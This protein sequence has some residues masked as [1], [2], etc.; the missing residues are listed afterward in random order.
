LVG[1][2]TNESKEKTNHL[3]TEKKRVGG[4]G[5]VPTSSE[6]HTTLVHELR[7]KGGES[8]QRGYRLMKKKKGKKSPKKKKE[9]SR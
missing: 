3:H 7:K 2:N 1:G 9:R 4:P 6:S 8:N 5:T